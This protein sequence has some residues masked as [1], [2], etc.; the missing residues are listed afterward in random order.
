MGKRPVKE[1][2]YYMK[3]M[4]DIIKFYTKQGIITSPGTQGE[5]FKAAPD[6]IPGMVSMIQNLFIHIHW[7]SRYGISVTEEQKEHVQ[8]RFVE[9]ILERIITLDNRPLTETR[10][11]GRRFYGN[12]RDFSVFLVSLL[13]YKG[14]PAVAR[15][16]FGT[17]FNPGYFEDHWV[18]EYWDEEKGRR[19][20]V[21]PQIDDLMRKRLDIQFDTLDMPSG[22]FLNAA[23]AWRLCREGQED[24][25]KFGIFDMRGLWFVRGNLLRD[26]A[27]LNKVELLPWDVWGLASRSE[28]EM[29]ESDYVLLD[30]A[31]AAITGES[32][33]VLTFYEHELLKVSPVIVSFTPDGDLQERIY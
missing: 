25:E 15:C 9:K 13:R 22:H 8:S 20:M 11:Y 16:G 2:A 29:S 28:S 3:S 21:D 27:A 1:K 6:D 33:E 4:R 10:P 31:A 17:Y 24:P 7:A 23:E 12:C 26:L 18:V 30:Q 14:I 19:V 32:N 5:L